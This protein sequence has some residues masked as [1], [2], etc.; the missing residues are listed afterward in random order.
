MKRTILTLFL[1][2]LAFVNGPSVG[3][4]AFAAD[5][6]RQNKPINIARSAH[7]QGAKAP[8]RVLITAVYEA[9]VNQVIVEFLRTAGSGTVRLTN[10]ATNAEACEAFSSTST[11]V[12]LPVSSEGDYELVLELSSGA[13]YYGTFN[14]D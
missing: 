8:A 9:T 3:Q 11:V 7:H 1:S 2:V 12:T 5:A 6:S 14:T 4:D 10:L 13:R